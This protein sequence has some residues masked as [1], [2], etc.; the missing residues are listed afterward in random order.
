MNGGG[1]R[2][3]AG[4]CTGGRDGGAGEAA[5]VLPILLNDQVKMT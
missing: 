4:T 1:R 5:A 3:K 2:V